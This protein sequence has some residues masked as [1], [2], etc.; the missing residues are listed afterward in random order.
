MQADTD[1]MVTCC[2][3]INNERILLKARDM[4]LTGPC[5]FVLNIICAVLFVFISYMFL[6]VV[7]VCVST[8]ICAGLGLRVNKL[9]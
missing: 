5:A 1:V 2:S 9:L 6:C 3:K 4:T 8:G 7:C